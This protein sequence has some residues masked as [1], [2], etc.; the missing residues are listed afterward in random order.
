MDIDTAFIRAHQFPF[1]DGEAHADETPFTIS[2]QPRLTNIELLLEDVFN[3]GAPFY[4]PG[5]C[6]PLTSAEQTYSVGA[7]AC[8]LPEDTQSDDPSYDIHYPSNN[9]VWFDVTAEE[10][11]VYVRDTVPPARIK[12]FCTTLGDRYGVELNEVSDVPAVPQKET[13]L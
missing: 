1:P 5:V 2:F 6:R 13:S 12:Q 8:P 11:D 9:T 7:I 10:M 3:G 4:M